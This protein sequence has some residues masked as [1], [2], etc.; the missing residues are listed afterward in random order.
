MKT[1]QTIIA[2]AC[3]ALWAPGLYADSRIALDVAAST[4]PAGKFVRVKLSIRNNGNAQILDINPEMHWHSIR[5]PFKTGDALSPGRVYQDDRLLLPTQEEIGL[6]HFFP[7]QISYSDHVGKKVNTIAAAEVRS[8]KPLPAFGQLTLPN[9]QLHSRCADQL[10]SITN[11]SDQTREYRFRSFTPSGIS[12]QFDSSDISVNA[13]ES[14]DFGFRLCNDSDIRDGTIPLYLVASSG[15][16]HQRMEMA[17]ASTAFISWR[18]WP[19]KI[20]QNSKAL[21]PIA[22]LLGLMLL[23]STWWSSRHRK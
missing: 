6:N 4:E 16:K 20:F 12:V 5:V 21:F 2:A 22:L 9:I 10:A 14:K 15:E 3:T 1:R 8:N 13:G 19:T 23:A 11:T 7:I 18:S 17:A